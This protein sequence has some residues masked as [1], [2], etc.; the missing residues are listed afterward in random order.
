MARSFR[1]AVEILGGPGERDVARYLAEMGA[2]VEG[3]ADLLQIPP[4][5]LKGMFALARI[6]RALRPGRPYDVPL[7]PYNLRA[8][9]RFLSEYDTDFSQATLDGRLSAGFSPEDALARAGCPMLLLRARAA[10]HETWGLLGAIDDEDLAR[11]IALVADLQVVQID[12]GHEIHMV[13]PRRY[14][15]ELVGFVDR[16]RAEG[17][18]A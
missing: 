7:L 2:P 18:L 10:R 16:L 6:N 3:K 14:V 5:I 4:A 11:I 12:S 17:K 15:D 9:F 8:G 13:Q 1:L